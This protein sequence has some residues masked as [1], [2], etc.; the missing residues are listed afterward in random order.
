HSIELTEDLTKISVLIDD[1]GK[2][3]NPESWDGSPV[4]GHHR[5]GF[6]LFKAINPLPKTLTLSIKEIGNIKNRDFSWKF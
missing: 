3:Y 1:K 5:S 4:G 2:I 6:L